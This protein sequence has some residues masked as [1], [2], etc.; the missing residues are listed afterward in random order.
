MATKTQ[1]LIPM[2][3]REINIP[4]S[5]QILN[6]TASNKIGYIED[7]FWDARLSGMLN[8]FTVVDGLD[9]VPPEA[10]GSN[11]FV[12]IATKAKDL[13]TELWMLVVIV[14]GFRLLRLKIMG[15]AVNFTAEAGPA[16]FEQQASATVLRSLLSNLQGR[17]QELKTQYSDEFGS[18]GFF[19]M[20]GV[21]QA[22]SADLENLAELSVL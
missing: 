9:V 13:P 22:A 8:T 1:D 15:L 11:Y 17:I 2:F 4:N 12:D 16:S 3:N 5:E 19:Y 20:D 7:G 6:L 10:T 14:G 18:A 21:S